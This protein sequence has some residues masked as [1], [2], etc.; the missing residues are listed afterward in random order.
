MFLLEG[1]HVRSFRIHLS[2]LQTSCSHSTSINNLQISFSLYLSSIPTPSPPSVFGNDHCGYFLGWNISLCWSAPALRSKLLQTRHGAQKLFSLQLRMGSSLFLSCHQG[3]AIF[4]SS[5]WELLCSGSGCYGFFQRCRD[6][7]GSV[8]RC[9]K[10]G[11]RVLIEGKRQ[12]HR[13]VQMR[14]VPLAGG[15]APCWRGPLQFLVKNEKNRLKKKLCSCS[16]EQ[17]REQT[18]FLSWAKS[19]AAR[20]RWQWKLFLQAD[21]KRPPGTRWPPPYERFNFHTQCCF[22]VKLESGAFEGTSRHES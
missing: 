2:Y 20:Y 12:P 15:G 11:R 16:W 1:H 21:C 18:K 7:N 14:S 5:V 9:T 6:N 19:E 17:P 22:A 4:S 13:S 10:T 8:V 3:R